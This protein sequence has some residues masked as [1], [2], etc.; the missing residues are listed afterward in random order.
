MPFLKLIE[1]GEF[2]GARSE[3]HERKACG[4]GKGAMAHLLSAGFS[5]G[6]SVLYVTTSGD[7]GAGELTFMAL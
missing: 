4:E 1:K 5:C 2:P 7:A 6:Q 3:S